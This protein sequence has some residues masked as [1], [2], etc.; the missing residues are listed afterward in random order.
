[1]KPKIAFFLFAIIVS[2]CAGFFQFSEP[3]DFVRVRG[4]KLFHNGR[5][6]YF[7]GTNMWY[8]FYLGSPGPTGD[9][10]RLRREL[11]SLLSIGICNIRVLAAS[12]S[13]YFKH[14][15]SPAVQRAPGIVDQELLQ[16][17]DFLLDE[18]GERGMHAVLYLNNYWVWS[19]GMSQ[20]NVWAGMEALDP[21][22]EPGGWQSYMDFAA[23]FYGNEAA[24]RFYR[25]YIRSLIMRR[26]SVNGRFYFEDPTIMAWQLANEPR[27]GAVGPFG[28]Q[29]AA[30]FYRWIDQT[31]AFIHS[32][33]TNHLVS[34]GSEG[35]V[36]SLLSA[37]HFLAAHESRSVDYLTFHLWPF[38]WGWF[39]PRRISETLP[40]AEEKGGEYIRQHLVLA[41]KMRKP[42]VLEEFG[43]GRD[44]GAYSPRT[45]VTAR[46]RY[47]T[48]LLQILY[49]SARAGGALS[50]SNVW[51]WGGEGFSRNPD[52]WWRPGDPYVGDPPQEP[53]GINSVFISDSSTIAILRHF[54]RKMRMIGLDSAM[55]RLP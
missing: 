49:D 36:G 27:P 24:N 1:M 29:N 39:D 52:F 28:E 15:A 44:S 48:H 2:G 14:A 4:T 46:D 21:E 20:Y 41:R 33:D 35:V 38:N 26:N 34:T 6:Y 31:A 3:E 7:L 32:L 30:E 23:R 50:G 10:E 40:V 9:R 37:D 22:K 53:Q 47:F 55:V 5:P 45:P 18:M 19:G 8:G 12:E 11:D 54:A 16:G 25:D 43:L 17:L 42:I 51:A 13:S